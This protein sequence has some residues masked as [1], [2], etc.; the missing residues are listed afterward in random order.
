[1]NETAKQLSPGNR[2]LSKKEVNRLR[3]K[4]EEDLVVRKL[5]FGPGFDGGGGATGGISLEEQEGTLQT[6]DAKHQQAAKNTKITTHNKLPIRTLDDDESFYPP[7]FVYKPELCERPNS[8]VPGGS[9]ARRMPRTSMNST[10][11]DTG[12]HFVPDHVHEMQMSLPPRPATAGGGSRVRNR[13]GL[14]GEGTR[15]QQFNIPMNKQDLFSTTENQPPRS[16]TPQELFYSVAI[17]GRGRS[18]LVRE[19]I[20]RGGQ[21]KKNSE[22]D[23]EFQQWKMENCPWHNEEK[24]RKANFLVQKN[25]Q[26]ANAKRNRHSVSPGSPKVLNALSLRG[27]T[28]GGAMAATAFVAR[29]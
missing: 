29:S 5:L 15:N 4:R 6:S 7:P 18:G 10:T 25:Q 27:G 23:S 2:G 26:I 12:V 17:G 9:R 24:D 14:A 16:L 3:E 21:F 13:S 8:A 20:M 22:L 1:M 19:Q 11:N 28:H